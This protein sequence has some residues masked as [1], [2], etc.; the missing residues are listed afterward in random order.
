MA[1]NAELH[2]EWRQGTAQPAES[3][4]RP[5]VQ[6]CTDACLQCKNA[7]CS[8]A[9]W[10]SHAARKHGFRARSTLVAKGRP[11]GFAWDVVSLV[12]T[13]I[14]SKGTWTILPVAWLSGE[15]SSL[16]AIV[17]LPAAMC[18]PRRRC[19]KAPWI[20]TLMSEISQ[21]VRSLRLSFRDSLRAPPSK[22]CGTLGNTP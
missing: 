21:S 15:R 12:Q 2:H 5:S 4:E 10:A 6:D 17:T 14:V 9:A 3:P 8:L 16:L 11:V 13:S 1:A 7:F 18:K 20:W 22:A 19:T